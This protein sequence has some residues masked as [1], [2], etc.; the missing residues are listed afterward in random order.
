MSKKNEP[1]VEKDEVKEVITNK[2]TEAKGGLK[3]GKKKEQEDY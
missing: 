1:I 2:K 3:L